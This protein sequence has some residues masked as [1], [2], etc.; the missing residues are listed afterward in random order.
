MHDF[1]PPIYINV[2]GPLTEFLEG[3]AEI[4][5]KSGQFDVEVEHDAM[6]IDSFSVSNLRVLKSK[7]HKGLG[8]QLIIQPDATK[9]VAVEIRADRWSP[10]DPP[11]YETYVAEAKALIGPLLSEYNRATGNRY[12]I[13]IPAKG[14]LEPK[15]PPQSQKLFKRF[16]NLANRTGL[17]PLDWRRFYEFVRDSRMR[18]PL[19]EEDMVF[20]LNKEGFP[21]EYAREIAEIYTHLRNFKQ[22]V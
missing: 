4:A 21:E 5:E 11:T 1:L 17:H 18:K 2:S 10:Q 14:K 16:T 19:S 13:T 7:Q 9:E 22:L 12:R 8:G 20:L 6:G 3:M 15:L